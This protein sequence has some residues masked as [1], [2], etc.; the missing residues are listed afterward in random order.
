MTLAQQRQCFLS[1]VVQEVGRSKGMNRR[2]ME[3]EEEE[4]ED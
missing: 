2:K 3:G 1:D 4:E